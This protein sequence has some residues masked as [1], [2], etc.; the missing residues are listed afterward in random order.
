[1]K[2]LTRKLATLALGLAA[3]S[4]ALAGC[5]RQSFT[6]TP[7]VAE[8]QS[9]GSFIVPPKVDIL[10]ALDD[11]GS[12][13]ETRNQIRSQ[14]PGLLAK[15]EA[16]GWDYHFA[17]TPLVSVTAA[18]NQV[19]ASKHDINWGT[20][21]I[22]AFPGAPFTNTGL[23]SSSAFR[24]PEQYTQFVLPNQTSGV[25]P[26]LESIRRAL[27]GRTS[28]GATLSNK[29]PGTGFLRSDALLVIIVV[30]NGEDTSG[31]TMCTR[32][33]D[34]FL[35]ACESIGQPG[36]AASSFTSFKNSI[37]GLKNSADLVQ[38]HAAVA[39]QNHANCFGGPATKGARYMDMASALGGTVQDVC[40][41][42]VATILD[43]I[44]QDL[45]IQ[46]R[47]F[48]TKYLFLAQEPEESSI[49]ITKFVGGQSTQ[50]VDIP[51][52]AVNG[53]TYLGFQQN[54]AAIDYPVP[55]NFQTGYAIELHG[56]AKLLGDDTARVETTP[57]GAAPAASN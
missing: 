37:L 7:S 31:V 53:W 56:T 49:R 5:G 22:T 36:T 32:P 55:M 39:T 34:G 4:A 54:L 12:M 57:A 8:Q 21:R 13:F 6:V 23:V 45:G 15:M 25:E 35:V 42:S 44:E 9:P 38:L 50:A 14:M 51:R 16:S 18:V 52:D 1:M 48:R 19:M 47:S 40:T 29:L 46:R 43:K 41:T 20:E 27:T 28:S 30:G 17:T 26:G 2:R 11:S 10:L 3:S 24:K 33:Q